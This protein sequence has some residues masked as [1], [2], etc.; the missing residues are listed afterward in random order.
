LRASALAEELGVPSVSLTCEGFLGQAATT[1]AGLG[2][3]NL[4]VAR[5]PGHVDVQTAEE[6]RRNVLGVTVDEVI[7]GLTAAPEEAAD[8]VEPSPTEIVFEG[9][10]DEVN[11]HFYENGWSDGLP[12]VPPT[13]ERVREFSPALSGTSDWHRDRLADLIL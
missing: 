13:G 6:L 3:P 9:T 1:A 2:M 8:V 5:V 7:Q 10:Y 12:I 11:R 4:P